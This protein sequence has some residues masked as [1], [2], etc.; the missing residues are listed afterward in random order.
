MGKRVKI[1]VNEDEDMLYG[2]AT[3]GDRHLGSLSVKRSKAGRLAA[4]IRGIRNQYGEETL[5]QAEVPVLELL[6]L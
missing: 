6:E 4:W 5:V 2:V 3:Q 1:L